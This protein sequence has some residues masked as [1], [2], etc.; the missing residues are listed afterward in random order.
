MDQAIQ[1]GVEDKAQVKGSVRTAKISERISSKVTFHRRRDFNRISRV[2]IYEAGVEAPL[3]CQQPSTLHLTKKI[4]H[5]RAHKAEIQMVLAVDGLVV[6]ASHSILTLGTL[7]RKR[8]SKQTRNA[9]MTRKKGVRQ[10]RQIRSD[11]ELQR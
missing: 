5:P 11:L 1:N 10:L 6:R 8:R 3:R 2:Q 7:E 4:S 9:L